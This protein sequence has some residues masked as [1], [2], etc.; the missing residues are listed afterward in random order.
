MYLEFVRRSART[1]WSSIS[2][3][4]SVSHISLSLSLLSL[5]L[6]PPHAPLFLLSL[7]LSVHSRACAPRQLLEDGFVESHYELL[8]DR[9]LAEDGAGLAFKGLR[10]ACACMGRY[11]HAHALVD[12]TTTEREILKYKRRA[13]ARACTGRHESL[14]SYISL[15]PC[16]SV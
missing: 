13:T 6:H 15:S 3:S 2:F 8:A 5:S 7:S 16:L 9:L 10:R 11:R 1:P 4:T 14:T 12:T